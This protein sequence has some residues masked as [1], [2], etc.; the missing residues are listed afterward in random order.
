MNPAT[1]KLYLFLPHLPQGIRGLERHVI[2]LSVQELV[3]ESKDQEQGQTLRSVLSTQPHNH[4]LSCSRV[5]LAGWGYRAGNGTS[6]YL[7]VS[8]TRRRY[9]ITKQPCRQ[10]ITV[11]SVFRAQWEAWPWAQDPSPA[12]ILLLLPLHNKKWCIVL[13]WL[14]QT[15]ML[16]PEIENA[17]FKREHRKWWGLKCHARNRGLA[18][19]KG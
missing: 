11:A 14:T 16:Y 19:E 4:F 12:G 8:E 13:N 5:S 1:Q 3:N 10:W 7:E 18:G 2:W 17:I 6:Y 15:T 9:I